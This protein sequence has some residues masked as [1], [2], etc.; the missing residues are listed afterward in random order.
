MMTSGSWR[1]MWRSAFAKSMPILGWTAVWLNSSITISIG[2]SMVV[3]LMSRLAI[4]F[5]AE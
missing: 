3:M 1:R 5:S 4:D 2:S